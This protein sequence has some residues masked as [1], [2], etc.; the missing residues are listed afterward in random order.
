MRPHAQWIIEVMLNVFPKQND[1]DL[2]ASSSVWFD[3]L[4]PTDEEIATVEREIGATLPRRS[5]LSE[6]EVSSRL[7]QRSGVLTMSTPTAMH[8]T[9][10][11]PTVAPLGFVLSP[12]QLVTIRFGPLS[13]F[14][15]VAKK[16]GT[17][18]TIPGGGPEVFTELCEEIVD[19]VADVLEH[20]AAELAALSASAFRTEENERGR[21]NKSNSALRAGLRKVGRLGDHLS[22]VRDGLLGLSRV[23]A[24]ADQFGCT[25]SGSEIKARVASLRQDLASLAEYDEQLS[26]KVQFVLDALVGLIGIAQ[27]DVF[28]VLT[29]VSIVGIPPTLIAGVYGMNFKNMPEYDWT[30]GYQYG[31]VV[32]VLS[33]VVPLIWFKVRGWF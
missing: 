15:V 8:G 3:L 11:A 7:R 19:H 22:E 27:N 30:F 5:A 4:C 29:I 21:P 28:K 14:D 6:I 1:Q 17:V 31:L 9:T 10:G 23:L 2:A 18:D 20:V 26:N 24:F 25:D 16:F 32:I 12:T 33:A 13:S